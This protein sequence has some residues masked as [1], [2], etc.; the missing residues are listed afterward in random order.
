MATKVIPMTEEQCSPLLTTKAA[1]ALASVVRQNI[2]VQIEVR[3]AALEGPDAL[4][5]ALNIGLIEAALAVT[6]I[7]QSHNEGGTVEDT[8][9]AAIKKLG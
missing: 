5:K 8:F 3:N 6:A 4:A 7:A 9:M 1:N 2:L